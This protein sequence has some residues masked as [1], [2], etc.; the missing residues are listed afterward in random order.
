M[1][2]A[3][4]PRIGLGTR[5]S[6]GAGSV[7]FGVASQALSTS[8][9]V[10]FLNQAVGVPAVLVG[11]AIMIS[12]IIDAV[13][14]PLVGQW[15]DQ[16]RTRWG[17]RHPFMYASAVPC[18]VSFWALWNPPGD[19][20]PMALFA[21]MVGVLAVVRFCTALYEIPSSALAPEL[22]PDYHDRTSLIAY[23]W[24]F[25]IAGAAVMVTLLN[26]VFL[27]RDATHTLGVLNRAG[28]A[29]WGTIAAVVIMVSILA[30]TAATHRLIPTLSLAP[31]RQGRFLDSLRTSF[32]ALANP[33]MAA[34]MV[35]GLISGVAGGV[36]ATVNPFLYL[37][38]WGLAPQTVSLMVFASVPA[39]LLG[40]FLAPV[41]ARRWGKKPT[42]ISLFSVS[43]VASLIPISARLLGLLPANGSVWL[44]GLL[45]ADAFLAGVLGLMGFIIVSSMVADVVEDNAARTGVRSEGLLFAAN[46]LLPKITAGV[47]AF[48]GALIVAAVHF[49]AHAQ[50]G[51]VDPAIVH[52]LAVAYLPVSA[53]MSA[54]AIFVLRFYRI[55]QAAHEQN[56]ANL[57]QA[58]AMA[59]LAHGEDPATRAAAISRVT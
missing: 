9:I 40:T 13:V 41:A 49:P 38:F 19:W 18:A 4:S 32:A 24:L 36:T 48:L 15:S 39:T 3:A 51:S 27:R 37:Y 57:A 12:Q 47:G 34:L 33:S 58:A 59:E 53:L 2:S 46:G 22:A 42:M 55:D 21:Y 43:L 20:G 17:R 29:Q 1:P 14:D 10:Q 30:S 8:I 35:S 28:Y 7:A 45:M 23:R 5:L 6:Y 16:V 11:A 25:G 44:T 54:L 31:A 50:Q 56:L 52:N 26:A